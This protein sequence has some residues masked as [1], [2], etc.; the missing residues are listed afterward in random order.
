MANKFGPPQPVMMVIFVKMMKLR[1]NSANQVLRICN[2]RDSRT[3]AGTNT[4]PECTPCVPSLDCPY[5]NSRYSQSLVF[6]ME[7]VQI[8]SE[9]H[10]IAQGGPVD[11]GEADGDCDPKLADT[12]AGRKFSRLAI[13]SNASIIQLYFPLPLSQS[14]LPTCNIA[15]LATP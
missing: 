9:P 7:R 14:T 5:R 2:L 8:I 10:Y 6:F 3:D 11:C 12:I 1:N 13:Q 4:S 15:S